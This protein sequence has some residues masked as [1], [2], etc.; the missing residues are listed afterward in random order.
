LFGA[1][2]PSAACRPLRAIG[3]AF[4]AFDAIA[5]LKPLLPRAFG[6][7]AALCR[8]GPCLATQRLCLA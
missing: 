2:A 3:T 5:R 7:D 6:A 8:E 1:R 4:D